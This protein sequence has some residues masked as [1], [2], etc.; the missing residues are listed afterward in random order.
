MN[1]FGEV[2]SV[3]FIRATLKRQLPW[4]NAAWY[5]TDLEIY[6][7]VLQNGFVFLDEEVL[8]YFPVIRQLWCIRSEM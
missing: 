5:A 3:M 1:L 7:R 2:S 6:I 8:A 4:S